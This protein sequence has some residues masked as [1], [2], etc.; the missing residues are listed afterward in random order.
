MSANITLLL[1]SHY[2]LTSRNTSCALNFISTLSLL[3]LDRYLCWWARPEYSWKIGLWTLNT[4]Q[5]IN[6][7]ADGL[8]VIEDIIRPLISASALT[9]FIR[10]IHYWNLQFL[11]NVIINK[12]KVLLHQAQVI[13]V[14]V[15][16]SVYT[17][18]FYYSQNIKLFGFPIFRFER[19]WWKL[20]QKRVVR[21]KF[22]INVFITMTRSIL[23]LMNY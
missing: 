16:Y 13:L 3:S 23:L 6:Q 7:S 22:D 18:W 15:G 11:N 1:S 17:L 14:D 4:N 5:S 2:K 20:F 10:C 19:T 12:T 8:L 9:W 21:I